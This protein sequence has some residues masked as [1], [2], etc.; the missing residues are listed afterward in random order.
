MMSYHT[1]HTSR[2]SFTATGECFPEED[3]EF[4]ELAMRE[5]SPKGNDE[6]TSDNSE[7]DE[8][9]DLAM[10]NAYNGGAL[11]MVQ[12][13]PLQMMLV[14]RKRKTYDHQNDGNRPCPFVMKPPGTGFYQLQSLM[15]DCILHDLPGVLL[16]LRFQ[17][18]LN[19]GSGPFRV[20]L[21]K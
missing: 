2:N 17:N 11:R 19:T 9:S 20:F 13:F 6:D 14:T 3:E 10:K 18:S 7:D 1:L 8:L 15:S 12:T 21:K 4:D 5:Y 16:R